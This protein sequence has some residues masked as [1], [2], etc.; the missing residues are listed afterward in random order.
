MNSDRISRPS[1]LRTRILDNT[2]ARNWT[3]FESGD[4]MTDKAHS[5]QT[6]VQ[7]SVYAF[8]LVLQYVLS[9]SVSVST[10]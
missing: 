4:V 3:Y 9:Y 1:G 7:I 5:F 10:L 6:S 2:Y 8:F